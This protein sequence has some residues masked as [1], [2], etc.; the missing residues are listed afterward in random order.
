MRI[1]LTVH[2]FFPH[3]TF[4]T[5]VYTL[6]LARQ[7][8][9]RRHRVT[10]ITCE[11]NRWGDSPEISAHQDVWQGVNV[12][13]LS[14]NV[15]R[16]PNPVRYDYYNPYIETY[17]QEFYS[18]YK[19]DL[20]HV[21]HPGNLS[22]AVITAAKKLGIPVVT[23]ATDFWYICPTS[24]LL[25][26]DRN[27][28]PGPI[29]PAQCLLCYVYQRKMGQRYRRLIDR[30]PIRVL[31]WGMQICRLPWAEYNWHTRMVRALLQRREWMLQ[32]LE[33]TDRIISPSRFLRDRL[34]ENGVQADKIVVSAHGIETEWV[35]SVPRVRQPSEH[36]R[37][38]FIGMVGWHKG[39]HIAVQAFNRLRHP[40]GATLTLY[41]DNQHFADYF[42]ELK[43]QIESNSSITY[44]GRFP[45]S[46][47]AEI[48]SGVDV[49]LMPSLWYE[50]TP[51]IMYEAFATKTPVIATHEGGMTELI[52]EFEGGWTFPRGDVNALASLMQELIDHPQQ[53]YEACERIRPVR[54][55]GEHVIDVLKIYEQVSGG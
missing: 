43:P 30:L 47:I 10:V 46:Q 22:T 37:F 35:Q 45:H 25:R 3:S 52:D 19:A 2:A 33:T 17:L 27:L 44:A 31:N 21:C 1:I 6:A 9:R 26:Y 50:N 32:T 36:L 13:R 49:L 28:C 4:G 18:S 12:Q 7:I 48:L 8:Q 11:S 40:N 5:E 42:H 54:T 51:V 53:V 29:H 24:Q 39:P 14:F 34:V 38:A 16:T 15:L 20:V 23:T 55:I 41:G